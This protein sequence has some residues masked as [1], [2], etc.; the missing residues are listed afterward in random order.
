MSSLWRL[1][2]SCGNN[3]LWPCKIY[4]NA[5]PGCFQYISISEESF[6]DHY[7]RLSEGE[8]TLVNTS[9]DGTLAAIENSI[10]AEFQEISGI[11]LSTLAT[12]Y[13]YKLA[14]GSSKQNCKMEFPA[15]LFTWS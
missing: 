14:S 7:C 8:Q 6:K 4:Y 12:I 13:R 15:N 1:P 10:T 9:T 11:C 2:T 5:I 3:C